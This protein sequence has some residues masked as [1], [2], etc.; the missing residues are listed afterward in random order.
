[1]SAGTCARRENHRKECMTREQMDREN[2]KRR[3]RYREDIAYREGML[4]A[5]HARYASDPEFREKAIAQATAR[6]KEERISQILSAL[7]MEE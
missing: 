1:M 7:G 6:Y 3:K 4:E 2:E 5:K